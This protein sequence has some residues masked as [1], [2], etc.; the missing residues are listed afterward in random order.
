MENIW[1][2]MN[3]INSSSDGL[4]HG[5][6]HALL[7]APMSSSMARFGDRIPTFIRFASPSRTMNP[8]R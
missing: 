5:R 3:L 8:S 6:F 4:H 7:D 2:L 1:T